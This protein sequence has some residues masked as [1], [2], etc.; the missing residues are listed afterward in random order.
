MWKEAMRKGKGAE[1]KVKKNVET[2]RVGDQIG[3]IHLGRQDLGELQSRKMKGLKRGRD[4][5]VEVGGMEEEEEEDVVSEDEVVDDDSVD[6]EG[7]VPIKRQKL[8]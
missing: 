4:E 7:G 3:R 1:G 6:G 2:D 5:E 8:A